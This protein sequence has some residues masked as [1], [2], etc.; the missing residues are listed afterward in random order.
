MV[1]RNLRFKKKCPS[2]FP[3]GKESLF[4]ISTWEGAEWRGYIW[5]GHPLRSLTSP[6]LEACSG[7]FR[8]SAYLL[9]FHSL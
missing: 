7:N 8:I 5:K 3:E 9:V 2:K 4:S 1:A 6:L